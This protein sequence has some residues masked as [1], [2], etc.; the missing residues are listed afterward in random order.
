MSLRDSITSLASGTYTVTRTDTGTR[1][2][3]FGRYTAGDA[4][5]FEIVASIQPAT[6]RQ[7]R[8]LPEGQRGDE[9]IAIYTK[10]EIRTRSPGEPGNE[11][12]VIAYRDEPW[13]VTQVKRWESFGAVHFEALAVRAPDPKGT[14]P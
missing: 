7:L 5:T 4:S 6:G 1:V 10:T 2:G 13:T 12:D 11:P 3:N 9:T 14:V 8:D